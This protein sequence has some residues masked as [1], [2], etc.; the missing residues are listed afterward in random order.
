[1]DIISLSKASKAHKETKRL[2]ESIIGQE[3]EGRFKTVDHR[4][5][6]LESQAENVVANNTK[7]V[8]LS[9]GEFE[10][11]EFKDRKLSLKTTI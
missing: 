3:A 4:L 5:D 7:T 6:W 9:L 10:S 11:T 8:D 2:D 1:M